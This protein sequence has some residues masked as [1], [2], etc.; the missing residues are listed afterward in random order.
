MIENK[1]ELIFLAR[2]KYKINQFSHEHMNSSKTKLG[3]SFQS[4]D[5]WTGA[6]WAPSTP[7]SKDY[8]DKFQQLGKKY[9]DLSWTALDIPKIEISDFAEFE[10]IW[11]REKIEIQRLL[12]SEDEPW[13]K[14]EHP[15]GENS[16]WNRIE[17]NGLHIT[18]NAT[19]DFNI[20]DLYVNGKLKAPQYSNE[21]GFRQGRTA[22]G[23]FTKKL[24]KHKF[25]SN[26]LVQIMDYFPIRVLNNVM[27]LEP[28]TD[29][30]PHREQT[31]AWKCPTEFRISLYD[32]NS[33][34]TMYLT[35]IE[36]GTTNYVKL[37]TS[38]NSFCWSNGTH[39]YGMDYY[40][41]KN[42]H[43]VVNAIW[44]DKKLDNLLE[45]S[46]S[47]YGIFLEKN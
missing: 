14:E 25:F 6:S 29:V 10:E 3:P 38:T 31:W 4:N 36:T 30:L 13:N 47:K 26:L 15:L 43:V 20:H 9:E 16:S 33:Q 5:L 17:F 34:P 46:V 35:H 39:I 41:Q 32:S 18:C 2:E 40:N 8:K 11:N 24:Y 12:P 45:K 28:K 19:L 22:Q 21:T 37:P 23:T 42:Y 7:V 27:I 1:D 44:D